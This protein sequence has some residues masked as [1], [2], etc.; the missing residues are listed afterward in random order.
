MKKAVANHT[1]NDGVS[2][3]N[4]MDK[5]KVLP[6]LRYSGFLFWTASFF[7]M[8]V[9]LFCLY[10]CKDKREVLNQKLKIAITQYMESAVE[11]FKVDSIKILGIDSLTDIQYV[12][13]NKVIYQNFEEQLEQNYILYISPITEQEWDEQERISLQLEK[14]KNKIMQCDSIL[15]D[16]RTDTVKFQYFFVATHVFGRNKNA[17]SEV[18][19]IGFPIDKK[20]KVSELEWE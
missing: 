10:G 1:R 19:E 13:F 18:H 16:P 4:D 3:N 7:A 5:N 12:Y 2:G 6:Y 9:V 14:I 11:G 8:M 20:F 15:L 17:Q